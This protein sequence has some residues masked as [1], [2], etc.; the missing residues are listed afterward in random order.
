M[1]G[2]DEL[3][4]AYRATR[5]Q[6]VDDAA[7]IAVEAVIDARSCATDAM[8]ARHGARSGVFVTAWNPRSRHQGRIANETAQLRLEADLRARGITCLAHRGVGAD[9][10]WEPELGV[11]ALDL[12]VAE[13]LDLILAYGQNALVAIE[14]GE[15]AKLVLT[16]LMPD[17]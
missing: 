6:V 15:P 10:A 17:S 5:Y 9:P 7:G 14:I 1:A 16:D 8:L 12:P 2:R 4:R 13:A 11:L 3:L